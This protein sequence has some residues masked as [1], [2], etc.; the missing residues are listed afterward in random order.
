[1]IFA[2]ESQLDAWK[3]DWAAWVET[4]RDQPRPTA[5]EAPP[6]PEPAEPAKPEAPPAPAGPAA[7][8]KAAP[9]AADVAEAKPSNEA[10][11]ASDP[12]ALVEKL[13]AA[14]ES[15]DAVAVQVLRREIAGL[16]E[17]ATP[18]LIA[19]LQKPVVPVAAIDILE[20]ITKLRLGLDRA[21]WDRW[22]KSRDATRKP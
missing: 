1:M 5:E 2:G 4:Y 17:R 21:A 19:A 13:L 16:G 15:D 14:C 10:Q 20:E 12:E 8:P 18:A 6:K 9:P 3:K 7:A 22:W 11:G